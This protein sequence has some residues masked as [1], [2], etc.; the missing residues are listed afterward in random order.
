ML[1]VKEVTNKTVNSALGKKYTTQL[2]INPL[3]NSTVGRRNPVFPFPVQ[4]SRRQRFPPINTVKA[5][6]TVWSPRSSE[7]RD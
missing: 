2:R 7:H 3:N 1:Y 6:A 4:H 5:H